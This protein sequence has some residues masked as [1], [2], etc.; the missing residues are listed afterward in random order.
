MPLLSR[1]AQFR[2]SSNP[3]WTTLAGSILAVARRIADNTI[4]LT[5][6][7]GDSV[8]RNPEIEPFEPGEDLKQRGNCST[9]RWGRQARHR[10]LN[11]PQDC[12]SWS[13]SPSDCQT[14]SLPVPRNASPVHAYER[15]GHQPCA[16]GNLCRFKAS[17]DSASWQTEEGN[18]GMPATGIPSQERVGSLSTPHHGRCCEEFLP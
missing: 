10:R 11:L 7:A 18:A 4:A 8:E 2:D 9:T 16:Q 15:K 17:A 14:Q 13:P 3:S 6:A 1:Q 5:L 12:R